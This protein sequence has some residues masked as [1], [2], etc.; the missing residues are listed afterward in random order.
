MTLFLKQ[1]QIAMKSHNLLISF[2]LSL[3][4]P[5]H[6][7]QTETTH[8]WCFRGR[9]RHLG[10]AKKTLSKLNLLAYWHVGK[11]MG[12]P[13]KG[14]HLAERNTQQQKYEP[15]IESWVPDGH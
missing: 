14:I 13:N 6:L 7:L 15:W 12:S 4:F 5:N 8:H 11:F 3:L 1:G 9:T 2:S 10:S